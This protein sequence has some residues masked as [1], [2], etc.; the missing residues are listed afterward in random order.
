MSFTNYLENE[1]LDHTF[2]SGVYTP[3]AIWYVGLS[4]TV[5]DDDGS[6]FTEPTGNYARVAVA[7]DKTQWSDAADFAG[8]SGEVHN[9]NSVQF[10]EATNDWGT[11]AHFAVFDASVSGNCAG[12]GDLNTST[13]I[14]SGTTPVFNSGNLSIRL[15]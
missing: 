7:N 4:T 11:V 15:S 12:I 13:V 6:N 2:G 10:V 9:L 14:N 1:L 8:G 3:P 5:P